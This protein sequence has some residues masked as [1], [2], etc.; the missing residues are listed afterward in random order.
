MKKLQS[1]LYEEFYNSLNSAS[2]PNTVGTE[3]K[4]NMS[5]KLNLPPKSKSPNRAPSRRFSA[6][7]DVAYAASPGSRSKRVSNVG[8]LSNQ[9][10]QEA[11]SPPRGELKE[12]F[13]SNLEPVSPRFVNSYVVLHSYYDCKRNL[14]IPILT[15]DAL[16]L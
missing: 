7:V 15:Y 4:E 8:S 12:V 11:K 9:T 6:A 10:S 16:S 1:P 2:P 13:D 14:C 5:N 3:D